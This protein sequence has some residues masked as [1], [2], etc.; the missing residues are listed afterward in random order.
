LGTFFQGV[1][2]LQRLV[3]VKLR[4]EEEGVPVSSISNLVLLDVIHGYTKLGIP[5]LL[6]SE[7]LVNIDLFFTDGV[8]SKVQVSKLP[9][10]T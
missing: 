1:L 9:F 5:L 4:D 6:I 3:W 10:Y 7:S 2:L 8:H